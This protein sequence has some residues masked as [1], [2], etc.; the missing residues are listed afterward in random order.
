MTPPVSFP[1]DRITITVDGY[2]YKI[3]FDFGLEVEWWR[4][5][6]GRYYVRL[7]I[8]YYNKV[9]GM[10]GNWNDDSTDDTPL[11]GDHWLTDGYHDNMGLG[12]VTPPDEPCT[13]EVQQ[14]AEQLCNR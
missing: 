8:A 3:K 1:W 14:Q 2:V 12:C 7:P 4:Q 13:Q 10:C 9:E 5:Q 11:I 6:N